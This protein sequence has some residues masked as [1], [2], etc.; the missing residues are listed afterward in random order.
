MVATISQV[1]DEDVIVNLNT[2]GT[3]INGSDYG[4]L[5]RITVSAGQTTGTVAFDPTDDSVYEGNET[6]IISI[7]SV[8]GAPETLEIEIIA[9]SLPS[10]T[11]SSVGSNAT[12]PVVCPAETVILVK[13]P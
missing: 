9:V 11:L 8:S 3:S 1:A 10:Y 6:A 7:S 5:T 12:V 4:T 2:A 13:V